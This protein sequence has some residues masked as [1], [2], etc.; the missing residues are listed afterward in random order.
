MKRILLLLTVLFIS[1]AGI[2]QSLNGQWKGAFDSNGNIVVSGDNTTEY[3]LEL[4]IDGKKVTGYSYSYFNNKQ[5]FVICALA[6]TYNKSNQTLDVAET[7]RIKGAT[8]PDWSDCL[9]EHLLS[10]RKEA[11]TEV[12]TGTWRAIK[13]GS[14][15]CGTG[16]TTLTRK[17][18]STLKSNNTTSRDKE[19][20]TTTKPKPHPAIVVTPPVATPPSAGSDPPQAN[21]KDSAKTSV[22]TQDSAIAVAPVSE[23]P[24]DSSIQVPSDINYEK[25]TN[26]ILQTIEIEHPSFTVDLYDNGAIDGDS[27]SLFYNNKVI[28]FHKRLS[29]QAISITLTMDSTQKVNDLTMYAENLGEIPPN[30]ALLVIM[31]GKKRYEVNVSSDLTTSG[32]VRFIFNTAISPDNT[33]SP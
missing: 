19:V 13:G 33:P 28:L 30:T 25:R 20:A 14:S 12:L 31:D 32:S 11:N 17:T 5:F 29:E 10:Y 23:K 27:I 24:K 18:L 2:T 9:Q 1:S 21:Q 6:G 4:N 22:S 8:P 15:D 16:F 26:I 3:M 7:K